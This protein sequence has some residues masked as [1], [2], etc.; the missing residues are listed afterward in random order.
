MEN[1]MK[2]LGP[3]YPQ[4][5]QQRFG[6]SPYLST[7]VGYVIND[8]KVILDIDDLDLV[9]DLGHILDFY[10]KINFEGDSIMIKIPGVEKPNHCRCEKI[11]KLKI[12][13]HNCNMYTCN[14]CCEYHK[15]HKK[16]K[17]HIPNQLNSQCNFCRK[18]NIYPQTWEY[19]NTVVCMECFQKENL[20]KEHL[21]FTE[22]VINFNF[23]EWIPINNFL[24]N[25]NVDSPF[26]GRKIN[27][28]QESNETL[29]LNLIGENIDYFL[30][31]NTTIKYDA[32]N[33]IIEKNNINQY[34]SES[35]RNN[36]NFENNCSFYKEKLPSVLIPKFL[37]T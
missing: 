35:I 31:E 33:R 19:G 20:S 36:L 4:I 11:N 16:T 34:T 27:I 9:N 24:E 32:I 12:Y 29:K 3:I 17:M 25:R 23:Y 26:Y 15:N 5:Y 10:R 2:S 7:S 1:R 37:E 14:M 18:R 21:K 30:K 6:D 13:C 22:Y 28:I 8:N